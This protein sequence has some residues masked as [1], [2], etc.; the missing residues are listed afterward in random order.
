[1]NR[2]LAV[3]AVVALTAGAARAQDADPAESAV[4]KKVHE[5]V[6]ANAPI[7]PAEGIVT[8]DT[9]KR[10]EDAAIVPVAIRSGIAQRSDR[11]SDTI[12]LIVD[13][14]PSPIAAVF[15]FTTASAAPT[16]RRA[17]ASSN[18]RTRAIAE[19]NDGKLYMAVNYEGVRRLLGTGR[20]GRRGR[21]GV[22][23][24]DAHPRRRDAGAPPCSPS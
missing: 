22:A 8:L 18:T 19:T 24:Q 7:A 1:M 10:A 15:H 5:S 11:F 17:S 16:W 3:V 21:A 20:Q 4:W 13:N 12:W 23:R 9:P 2:W 14:N 6:F